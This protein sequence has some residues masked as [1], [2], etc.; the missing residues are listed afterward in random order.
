MLF[1]AALFLLLSACR[2][3]DNWVTV[4]RTFF[5]GEWTC[6]STYCMLTVQDPNIASNDELLLYIEEG[7]PGSNVWTRLP[8][9][10]VLP[11]GRILMFTYRFETFY[12]DLILQHSDGSPVVP[13]PS[14]RLRIVFTNTTTN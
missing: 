9:M 1:L 3:E 4:G 8:K 11:D 13:P 7:A 10:E 2:P 12:L 5:E 14:C 6:D